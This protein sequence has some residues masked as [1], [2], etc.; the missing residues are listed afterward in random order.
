MKKIVS[1]ILV[2]CLS[3]SLAACS[4]DSNDTANKPVK[5]AF[6]T[7]NYMAQQKDGV[8]KLIA[9][10]KKDNPD[11]DVEVVYV[12]SEE[13]NTKIQADIAAGVEPDVIQVVFDALD[14]AQNNYG[15][16]DL[17]ELVD[18]TELEEHLKGFE[19][20]ALNVAKI[21]GKMLGL[22]Y[23]FSTPVLFYN[24]TLLEEAGLD[25]DTP[26]TTW[27]EVEKYALQIKEQTSNDGFLFGGYLL[28]DCFLQALIKSNGGSIM[29][30]DRTTIQ[31]GEQPAIEALSMLKNMVTNG[32][33]PK[34]TDSMQ[35][36]EAFSGGKLGM[37]LYTSAL[38]ASMIKAADEGGWELRTAKM[39]AFGDKPAVPVNTGSGLF[40]CTKDKAKQEAAW[41]FIK[42]VTSDEGYTVITSMMGYP[43]L[44]PAIIE[45]ERYLKKWAEE[46]PLAGP[47]L[48]QL[49]IVTPWQ[50]YPGNNWYQIEQLLMDASVKAVF[51]D[52]D[53]AQTMQDAQNQA[54]SLMPKK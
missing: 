26:P 53:V 24:A 40:I 5:I 50:S 43:P 36:V 4:S 45:D 12:T 48:E 51:T 11:I 23:T 44:R 8:D 6:Y 7:Y 32:A 21:D 2:A 1:F 22:P 29:S 15:V 33:Q 49:K 42:Y 28:S 18:K 3:L 52:A 14:F 47:N 13:I 25:P 30:S 31:Y 19:P 38:Q 17:N 35:G 41:K 37:M 27:E 34:I 9:D 10:F 20:A 39:P 46:N 16:Q 54:Q